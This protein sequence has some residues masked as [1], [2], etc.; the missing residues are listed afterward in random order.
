VSTSLCLTI[1]SIQ[2]TFLVIGDQS[3]LWYFY[4]VLLLLSSVYFLNF[5]LNKVYFFVWEY[6]TL[7]LYCRVPV[8]EELILFSETDWCKILIML[9]NVCVC[10]CVCVYESVCVICTGKLASFSFSIFV[11]K[12]SL[13]FTMKFWLLPSP[14]QIYFCVAL[15][16]WGWL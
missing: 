3:L 7:Y 5:C 15:Y 1:I 12:F 10:V 8:E 11:A 16:D 4:F 14:F 9:T 2:N 13:I 6:F